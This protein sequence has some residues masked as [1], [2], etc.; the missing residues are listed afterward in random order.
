M[1]KVK[2]GLRK[3]KGKLV[4]AFVLYLVILIIFVAPL[5]IA[6]KDALKTG[7]FVF[8]KFWS[9]LQIQIAKPFS[10]IGKAFSVEYIGMLWSTLW[11]FTLIYIV[12]I[13]IGLYKAMPKSEY[14]DIEHGS[15][16]WSENGE[17]YSVLSRNKGILLA[18]KNYLP[19][20]KRGNV[21]VL[22]VG[23]IRIW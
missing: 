20:N 10:S 9:S 6:I 5:S 15:S 23:R 8:E 17:Q 16:D 13:A 7:V 18:Q 4:I 12:A 19:I 22:V 11:K 21:N 14:D 3:I 1:D 2:R